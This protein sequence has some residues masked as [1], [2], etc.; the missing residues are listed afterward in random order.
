MSR[1]EATFYPHSRK[2]RWF[3]GQRNQIPHK[4]AITEAGNQVED[5]IW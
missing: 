5:N 2:C 4:K 3:V 1:S